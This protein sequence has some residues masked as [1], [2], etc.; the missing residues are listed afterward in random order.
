MGG[1]VDEGF[2]DIS[3]LGDRGG[4]LSRLRHVAPNDQAHGREEPK[5]GHDGHELDDREAARAR[6]EAPPRPTRKS[7]RLIHSDAVI[8]RLWPFRSLRARVTPPFDVGRSLWH[9]RLPAGPCRSG[10]THV[11]SHSCAS[12]TTS[13][14]AAAPSRS[15]SFT[16]RTWSR[17]AG[18]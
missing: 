17:R 11:R 14:S 7:A 12:T 15:G 3:D 8:G 2:L 18:T 4:S 6:V 9:D 16:A 13:I 10:A 5:E 1:H